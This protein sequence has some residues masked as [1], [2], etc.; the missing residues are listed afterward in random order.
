M[1]GHNLPQLGGKAQLLEYPCSRLTTIHFEDIVL[2]GEEIER[3]LFGHSQQVGIGGPG[4]LPGERPPADVANEQSHIS[5]VGSI[6]PVRASFSG[7]IAVAKLFRQN[8]FNPSIFIAG[9]T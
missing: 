7:R 6:L 2:D 5:D 4:T 9:A 3:L 8:A 1:P